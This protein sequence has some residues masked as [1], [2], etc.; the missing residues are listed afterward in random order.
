MY[1]ATLET[2]Y[3]REVLETRLQRKAFQL[4]SIQKINE[5]MAFESKN[6]WKNSS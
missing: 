1:T 5:K 6:P 4:R 3:A 2:C